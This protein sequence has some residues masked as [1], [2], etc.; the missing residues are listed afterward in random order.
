MCTFGWGWRLQK[1]FRAEVRYVEIEG[2][3]SLGKEREG[4]PGSVESP[5]WD[6]NSPVQLGGQFDTAFLNGNLEVF[7]KMLNTYT[8]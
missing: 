1:G 2:E 8:L 7:I 3:R 4:E 5:A 6:G